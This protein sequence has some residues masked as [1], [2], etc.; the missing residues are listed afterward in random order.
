MVTG[1]RRSSSS[2]D[3]VSCTIGEHAECDFHDRSGAAPA[4]E[5]VRA[6]AVQSVSA[7]AHRARAS[8]ARRH[9]R[10]SELG[11]EQ[12]ARPGKSER[13]Q[14]RGASG[15]VGDEVT[16]A[17]HRESGAA[18]RRRPALPRARV[19]SSLRSF[20][21]SAR[22]RDDRP[23]S[24]VLR[25]VSGASP[26]LS[27]QP[28]TQDRRRCGRRASALVRVP[29]PGSPRIPPHLRF[30]RRELPT[31]GAPER[32]CMAIDLHA[33]LETL[34]TVAIPENERRRHARHRRVGDR[35]GARRAGHRTLRLHSFPAEA[36]TI[37]DRSRA[38]VFPSQSFRP[39]NPRWS[40]PSSSVIAAALLP[41]RSPTARAFWRSA[42]LWGRCFSTRSAISIPRSR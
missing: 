18:E 19:L 3:D 16:R 12:K 17:A 34:P 32:G 36:K 21:G 7:R 37:R 27:I 11:V 33:R 13:R 26:L 10:G 30:H 2:I 1:T 28:A 38:S 20:R 9:V 5:L 39:R 22:A 42:L 24:R 8:S 40:N 31:S 29:V 6:G 41:A 35:E 4:R 23:D 14:D 15:V 25:R